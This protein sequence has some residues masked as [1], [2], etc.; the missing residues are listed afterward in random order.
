MPGEKSSSD[1]DTDKPDWFDQPAGFGGPGKFLELPANLT[2]RTEALTPG[3]ISKLRKLASRFLRSAGVDKPIVPAA[4]EDLPGPGITPTLSE[5]NTTYQS[6]V[7]TLATM[8]EAVGLPNFDAA[9]AQTGAIQ[10]A[11]VPASA[12]QQAIGRSPQPPTSV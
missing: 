3:R 8:R 12:H 11:A 7:G 10:E 5:L 9:N 2:P 4:V 6:P 1:Q